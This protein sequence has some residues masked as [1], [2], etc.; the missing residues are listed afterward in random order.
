M[1][2]WLP[3][4]YNARAASAEPLPQR[5]RLHD[6]TL[7][8]GQQAADVAFS[9]EEK[10][11]LVTHLADAGIPYTQAGFAGADDEVVAAIKCAA[12]PI[13][14][15][16]LLV[17]FKPDWREALARAVESGADVIQVL[18]RA[19]DEQLETMGLSH[20]DA[21]RQTEEATAAAAET[22]SE[23]WYIPSFGTVAD[24]TFLLELY[25]IGAE[26]GASAT[27]IADTLGVCTPEAVGYLVQ[28]VREVTGGRTVGVHCHNDF[29]LAIANTL[30]GIRAGAELAEVSVNGY[31][32]RA[33]N[34]SVAELALAL[35]LMYRVDSGVRLERL[36]D[37][38]RFVSEVAGIPLPLDKP[39]SGDNV[40][41]Q[42]LDIHV[43]L[44]K[45]R[46]RLMEPYAPELVG[47]RRALRLGVGTGP[48]AV[49][50]KLKE[51]GRAE[52]DEAVADE[53]A[54]LVRA[55]AVRQKAAVAE[56]EFLRLADEVLERSAAAA[57]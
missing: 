47:N 15:S 29:G 28:A 12:I 27:V 46:A 53:L 13:Q 14:L 8:E 30:A 16:V 45:E 35:E 7:R 43:A 56:D 39:I 55:A 23:V 20:A 42:K 18:V 34:C 36:A 31:G 40:F 26:A 41:A 51:L 6:I 3:N 50:A 17:A 32:E 21:R 49:R 10:V 37:L 33:G 38:E 44:T 2:G 54:K 5:V 57:K 1:T 19:G 4:P 48:I 25:R 24:E 22:G 52:P 11:A 9:L